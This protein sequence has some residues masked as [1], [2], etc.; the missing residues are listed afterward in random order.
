MPQFVQLRGKDLKITQED[1]IKLLPPDEGEIDQI[2]GRIGNFK[3]FSATQLV[4]NDLNHG[5]IWYVDW[6][7]IWN[8]YDER[9]QFLPCLLGL[10]GLKHTF[11]K[12]D[13]KNLHFFDALN[14]D[15]VICDGK[16]T[17]L[18]FVQWLSTLADCKIGFDE[19][20]RQFNSYEKTNVGIDKL[21]VV[22][23]P[24]HYDKTYLI[25]SQRPS[26][27]H[28]SA[29]QNI[30]RFYKA[31]SIFKLKIPFTK[32]KFQRYQL[33]EFQDTNGDGLPDETRV[34]DKEGND[35]REYLYCVSQKK[36]W[37]RKKGFNAYDSKYRRAGMPTSQPNFAEI[38]KVEYSGVVRNFS[39]VLLSPI[40]NWR[41]RRERLEIKNNNNASIKS[42]N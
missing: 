20:H 21:D 9:E 33:T 27:I 35:T 28:K 37:A 15:N 11:Y 3:T 36:Y 17:G 6:G 42:G 38:Y 41:N 14:M 19:G 24:R 32:I 30:N 29:R 8:G 4:L 7:V 22:Y 10:L 34:K 40:R 13:K 1:L 25:I 31:E 23:T 26:Q 2:Y 16:P 18:N 39:N 5:K 12:Y